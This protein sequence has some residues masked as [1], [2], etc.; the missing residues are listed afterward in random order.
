MSDISCVKFAAM[1]KIFTMST[2]SSDLDGCLFRVGRLSR[3]ADLDLGLLLPV[4]RHRLRLVDAS[5]AATC[6]IGKV[7]FA[8]LIKSFALTLIVHHRC[9]D[10]VTLISSENDRDDVNTSID[11]IRARSAS[12]A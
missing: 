10:R 8:L 12:S 2:V 4:H 9:H 6:K 1:K 3:V 7:N 11:V 5:A